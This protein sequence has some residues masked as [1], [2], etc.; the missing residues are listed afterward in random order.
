MELA[1]KVVHIAAGECHNLLLTD[2]GRIYAWGKGMFGRLGTGE[3]R[4]ELL[5][6][7]IPIK[8]YRYGDQSGNA[9][10]VSDDVK[11]VGIAAGAYHNLA[12]SDDGLIWSWGYNVYGQLGHKDEMNSVPCLVE[13]I[14]EEGS[15][16]FISENTERDKAKR[17]LKAVAIKAGGMMSLAIDQHGILWIWGRCPMPSNENN[18][19]IFHLSFISNPQPVQGFQGYSVSKVACGNEHVLALV[20]HGSTVTE[21]HLICYAW[22]SNTHGQLGLGN[23][24]GRLIPQPLTTFNQPFTGMPFAIA[25]GAFHSAVLTSLNQYAVLCSESVEAS[26]YGNVCSHGEGS[27]CWTFGL[28]ENGQLGHGTSE[29]KLLPESVD[30]LPK[31]ISLKLVECGLFH[32]CV[33]SESGYGWVWGMERGLG[34][35]PNIGPPGVGGGDALYPLKIVDERSDNLL[36]SAP[37]EVGCGAAHTVLVSDNGF[38]LWAWGRGQN[39][40]LG[41]GNTLDSLVPCL[42][43]WPPPTVVHKID[44]NKG[45]IEGS[46]KEI[47]DKL[48]KTEDD[49]GPDEHAYLAKLRLMELGNRL[50]QAEEEVQFLRDK[51]GTVDH[52]ANILHCTIFGNHH[53]GHTMMQMVNKHNAVDIQEEWDKIM[54]LASNSDLIRMEAFYRTMRS[55]VKDIIMKRKINEWTNQCLNSFS[56][57][58]ASNN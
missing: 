33:F 57:G 7:N 46:E 36:I 49:T 52:Y 29:N 24:D 20:N 35:C 50:S 1:M 27:L 4:D 32:T 3:D 5:P 28:G 11:I 38:K 19:E 54:E 18:N 31:P 23:K 8:M 39:G 51:L 34:L 21:E 12:L 43:S 17:E 6:A 37:V 14:I 45:L 42:V 48:T 22:G 44:A 55:K 47:W 53:P 13:E 26:Q 25:C 15:T 58:S 16:E 56:S 2:D 9:S 30:Q 41:R 10:V 40:V